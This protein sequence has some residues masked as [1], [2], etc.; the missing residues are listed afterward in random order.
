MFHGIS[1]IAKHLGKE[2][3]PY[4]LAMICRLQRKAGSSRDNGFCAPHISVR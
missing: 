3:A 2:S 1:H 4:D